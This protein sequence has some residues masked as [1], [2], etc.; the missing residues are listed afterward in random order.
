MLSGEIRA[1]RKFIR[2]ESF[3]DSQEPIGYKTV[4]VEAVKVC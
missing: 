4:S 3:V 2:E 1:Q